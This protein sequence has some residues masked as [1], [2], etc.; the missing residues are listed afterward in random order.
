MTLDQLQTPALN[1]HGSPLATA[2]AEL[3][4]TFPDPNSRAALARKIAYL[5]RRGSYAT[6][7]EHVHTIETHMSWIFLTDDRVYKLK[8]PVHT[9]YLDFAT[10]EARRL[11]CQREVRLNRRLAAGVYLGIVPLTVDPKGRLRLGGPGTVADWLVEMRRLPHELMLDERI[12]QRRVQPDEIRELAQTLSAFH[13]ESRPVPTTAEAYRL[14]FEREIRRTL[15][16]L[17]DSHSRL[18]RELVVALGGALLDFI[19]RQ[20]EL[21][22]ARAEAGWV[23]ECH[24]DLRPEHVCLLSPPAV[25]DALEF[26]R[27]FRLLDPADE[28]AHL[29]LECDRLG[30]WWIGPVLLQ[31]WAEAVGDAPPEALLRFYKG[32]RAYLRARLAYVHVHELDE[33]AASRWLERTRSYLSLAAGQLLGAP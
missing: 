4:E 14:R 22:D 32:Q 2:R 23:R 18:P 6:Q 10:V 30:A 20:G 28:M 12:R 16:T 9:D 24:G 27:A 15:E 19:G 13:A 3:P 17:S 7:P 1:R 31:G 25:I 33:P 8:K 26:Q 11:D 5:R 29:A 21:L